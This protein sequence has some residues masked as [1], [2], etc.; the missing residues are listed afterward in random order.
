MRLSSQRGRKPFEVS[1]SAEAKADLAL[2][3]SRALDDALAARFTTETD[4]EQIGRA[5]CRERV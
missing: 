2:E 4:L 1:L 3:M 5:S